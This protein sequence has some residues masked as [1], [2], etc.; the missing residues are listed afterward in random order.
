LLSKKFG[1]AGRWMTNALRVNTKLLELRSGDFSQR[2]D[3]L[4]RK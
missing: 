1:T 3:L 4:A 2:D